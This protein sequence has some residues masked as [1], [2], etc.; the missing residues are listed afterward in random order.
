MV[1]NKPLVLMILDGWG[2]RS[3]CADNAI[4]LAD[5]QNFMRLWDNYP[6]TLLK[7][8]GR[9]VGLPHGQMG[10]SEVGHLNIGSGRTVYQEI[11]RI[12]NSIDDES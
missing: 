4:T 2:N 6:H 3:A 7:C 8:S 12:D 10:N 5:P 9:D 1:S 11:S